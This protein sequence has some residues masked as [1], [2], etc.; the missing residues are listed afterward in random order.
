MA[1]KLVEILP[2]QIISVDSVMVYRG[3]D[4]GSAKPSK[5][6][7]KKFPHEMIDIVNL[8]EVFTVADFCNI[9]LKLIRRTHLEKKLPYL[10]VAQ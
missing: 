2:V 5:S 9:S 8:D 3:C 7:L 4:I 1:I 6:I 10:L